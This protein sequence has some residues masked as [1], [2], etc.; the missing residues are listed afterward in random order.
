MVFFE[1]KDDILNLH[2]LNSLSIFIKFFDIDKFNF[3]KNNT[4][5]YEKYL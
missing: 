5:Y 3:Y 1:F 2:T 4:T